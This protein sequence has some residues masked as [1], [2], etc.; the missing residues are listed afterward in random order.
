M[1][2]SR[3]ITF[4]GFDS[5]LEKIKSCDWIA[6]AIVERL[7][8]KQS[9]FARID[10]LR[11]ADA[12]VSSNTSGIPIA[13]LA[14]G[15]SEGFRHH[16]LGTHFFNPPRYLRL[17]EIIP[18]ADTDRAVIERI[19]WTAD[20]GLGKGVVIAKDSPG[21]IANRIGIFGV[22]LAMRALASGQY[23]VE[24]IDAITGPAIG[25]PKS[26]TF[27]T[28]DIAGLDILQH[29]ATDLVARLPDPLS[30]DG[31][32]LP[33]L[34]HTM[35]ERGMIGEKSGQGFYKR[36]GGEILAL[37]TATLEYRPRASV[38]IASLDA[39]PTEDLRARVKRIF[40][41][42]DKA[43]ALLRHTLAPLLVYCAEIAPAIGESID[44]IDRAMQWGFG[45]QLGPFELWDAIGLDTVLDAAKPA[46]IPTLVRDAMAR[47]GHTFRD[48]AIPPAAAGL[49][50]LRSAKGAEPGRPQQPRREPGRSRRQRPRRR[51]ALEDEHDRRRHH[52]DA[53]RWT[54]RSHEELRGARRLHRRQRLLGRCQ[55][56]AGA[57]RGAGRNW[58]E[59]DLMVRSFQRATSALRYADVPVV[60]ATCG[61]T[62]GG[63][64][65]IAL[66]GA[67]VQASA[68]TYMGLVEVGVG[69]IPAGGGAKEMMARASARH[70]GVASDPGRAAQTVFETIGFGK[71]STSA[72]HGRQIGYLSERDGVT[73]NRERLVG[74]AKAGGAGPGACRL[75]AS[76][77][78][79]GDGRRRGGRGDAEAR[80]PPGVTRRP[81]QRTRRARRPH[82]G[83]GAR[84]RIPAE[85]DGHSRSAYARS[86]A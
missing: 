22:A 41:A 30:Q 69:L 74:E 6:E 29:V 2:A 42:S 59:I 44:D 77:A 3:L 11:G 85:P 8:I 43:G 36:A 27:R 20:H 16:F 76:V 86:R 83:A 67:A 48:R 24:E 49:E 55:P 63:G 28:M 10:G 46:A 18:T 38:R 54:R 1:D 61:L 35:I 75:P 51:T 23:T 64:A 25:R 82:A 15:R 7:D 17:L 52:P 26:A 19:A 80:R 68:E 37:D 58:D 39:P 60:V 70:A 66:H 84:G 5:D 31:Y 73:M 62:L 78:G 45:W 40:T 4:G 81:H 53:A 47:P 57:A 71:V 9:L 21:F 56:D 34:V 13:A 14:E 12:I 50:I 65:E 79:H 32:A 33:P 72:P